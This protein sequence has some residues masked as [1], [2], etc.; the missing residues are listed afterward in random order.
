MFSSLKQG[1]RFV[2][3]QPSMEAF[4]RAGVLHDGVERPNAH[5]FAGVRE[6]YLSSR[7]S[8][9]RQFADAHG[10]RVDRWVLLIAGAGH[11]GKSGRVALAAIFCLGAAGAGFCFSQSIPQGGAMLV[12]AGASMMAA[13]ASVSSLVQLITT[14]E[15]RGR[16]MS[17]Y[18]VAFRGGMPL[19]NL[20]A[21]ALV[22]G[23]AVLGVLRIPPL[24]VP[25]VVRL[26][27]ALLALVALYFFVIQRRVA[28]L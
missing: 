2:R 26:D 3:Q 25:V 14:D 4:D 19:G 9:L 15:M 12:L 18:N 27:G 21:G 6:G 5:L 13:F 11:L 8:D 1:I 23:V 10:Y 7:A 16:V 17:V 20:L 28:N 22:R 24:S